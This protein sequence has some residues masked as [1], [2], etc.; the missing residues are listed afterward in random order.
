MPIYAELLEQLLAASSEERRAALQ[1]HQALRGEIEETDV[2]A[3]AER[4]RMA[5]QS[6]PAESLRLAE[7][8]AEWAELRSTRRE[9]S[10]ALALRARGVALRAQSRW[11]EALQAFEEGALA[12]E[13][14][15]DPLLAAQIPIAATETLAQLGRYEEALRLADD[16]QSRLLAQ[17]AREDAAKV[18]ANA[19]NIYFQQERYDPALDCWNRAL[20]EFETLGNAPAVSRLRMNLA[21]VLTHLGRI[22]EAEAMYAGA[23][24]VLEGAGMRVLV[25]G[26][27][28]NLG[29]L[30]MQSGR[31]AEALRSFER[32]RS[33]FE[34][35]DL[36][37]DLAQCDRETGDVHLALNLTPEAR[38]AYERLL[39][40]L[41]ERLLTA[42]AAR[43]RQS[44]ACALATQ[45]EPE[46]ARELFSQAETAFR[47]D[48]NE[49]G[50]AHVRLHRAERLGSIGGDSHGALRD[51]CSAARTFS[52][53]RLPLPAA[54]A[55][56]VAA[57][58]R[59]VAGEAPISSLRSLERTTRTGSYVALRWRVYTA[60]ARALRS[61]GKPVAALHEYRRAVEAWEAIRDR[62]PG[63][64]F[65][66]AFLSDKLR[67]YEELLALLFEQGS[68]E[69][70]TEAFALTERSR[71]RTL[72]ELLERV[73][74]PGSEA[75]PEQE[76]LLTRLRELRSRLQWDYGRLLDGGGEP[77]RF[78]VPDGALPD[79]VRELEVEYADTRRRLSVYGS[80]EVAIRAEGLAPEEIQA[81]LEPEE[82][83]V[84]YVL[85]G[86]EIAA[87]VLGPK[88]FH[89]VRGLA[90][91]QQV[92]QLLERLR[93]QWS[94]FRLGA[95]YA[96]RH[97]ARL[98]AEARTI[99]RELRDCVL[100]P[101]LPWLPAERLVVAPQGV[102]HSVPFHALYSDGE[103]SLDR[104]EIVSV[105]SAA[106]LRACRMRPP[107]TAKSS[108]LFGVAE[109]NIPS[110]ERELAGLKAVAPEAVVLLNEA[111]TLAAVPT[112]GVFRYLHFA[113]HAVLRRDNPLFSGLR[114]TDGWLV[115]EDL[116][117]RRLDCSLASLAACQTG[118][119]A[120]APGDEQLGLTRAFLHAGARAVLASLWTAHD[121][122]TAEL[123]RACYT[124]LAAGERRA[125]ALRGAQRE[126]RERY[127]H[128]YYWAAFHL[129]GER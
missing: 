30:Q 41:D 53:A 19:G 68:Q 105:P 5:A 20:A 31:Y 35:L 117:H 74:T 115:A 70:F 92:E 79:R 84:E 65:R 3:V 56:L 60:L 58:L 102:L 12:A 127:A 4:A 13:A 100:A 91:R 47:R 123:M 108:L 109:P 27:D 104:W 113:T 15:N 48:G 2:H 9:R 124:R 52:R 126:V 94:K 67:P 62:L 66:I 93:F 10:R 14:A 101:L 83:L 43:A 17:A 114:M 49:I 90:S 22:S 36:P 103:Y 7:I 21:N 121:A 46:A 63:E 87:F 23:R 32:A 39:P 40:T 112:E 11:T 82:R 42:E 45:G 95:A 122:A 33:V 125:A 81:L 26:I 88:E 59:I 18:L 75:T 129:V 128:P 37:R 119:H 54:H 98:E 8:A 111:A 34:E 120:L 86:D 78:P 118:L 44:L 38:A 1:R 61:L 51:A 25:A 28:G 64:E 99:L 57:E 96:E 97:S 6:D 80:A 72:L 24:E 16:L 76:Q 55:R 107:V 106:V 50:A 77:G 73:V 29:F 69:A 89:T 110:V 116:Y 85:L 71:S